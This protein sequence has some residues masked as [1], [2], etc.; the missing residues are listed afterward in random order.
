MFCPTFAT[1]LLIPTR[2]TPQ[3]AAVG[4]DARALE[5]NFQTGIKGELEGLI[6]CLTHWVEASAKSIL[7]SEPHEYWRWQ[8]HKPT[9]CPF[10]KG[11]VSLKELLSQRE[12]W[13][14]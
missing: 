7:V 9:L 4:S 12:R 14:Q 6:L 10:K 1:H 2:S 5:I 11:N 3:Q 13:W 8:N